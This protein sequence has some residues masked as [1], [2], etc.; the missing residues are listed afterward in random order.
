MN[1]QQVNYILAVAELQHFE[2]AAEKCHISQSTLSTMISKYEEEIGVKIFD[3]KTKPV[4][5]TREGMGIIS[6]LKLI[7]NQVQ[8]LNEK[9]RE[10]K[11]ELSGTLRIG[12]IPTVA[13]FLL[14]K[15]LNG[16]VK[17]FPSVEFEIKEINTS[18]I[19]DQLHKRDLDI[20]IMAIPLHDEA[21]LEIPLYNEP[22]VWYDASKPPKTRIDLN[23]ITFEN[24]WLLEEGH[25]LSTQMIRICDLDSCD[26]Q[27]NSNLN[28]KAGSIASL[29]QFV[30]MSKGK[31]LLPYLAALNLKATQKKNIAFLKPP[32]PMRNI[33]LVVHQH[34]VK[35]KIL[36]LLQNE[37]KDKILPLI[38]EFKN[39]QVI[40]P[41]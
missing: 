40:D 15:F 39:N 30:E 2:K 4:S 11:G 13:P 20:G 29:I 38:P 22:F 18:Q 26:L 28:F 32:V 12:V 36:Q 24:F 31:T 3:R 19:I 16:F 17:K 9:I 7:A 5:I 10:L 35:R 23:K 8:E 41:V 33:G 1:F 14:P 21:L 6:Q 34:F 27:E 37:I 25:C